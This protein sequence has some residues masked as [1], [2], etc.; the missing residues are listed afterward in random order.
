MYYKGLSDVF[1]VEDSIS[2]HIPHVVKDA[3]N[4]ST[5]LGTAQLPSWCQSGFEIN[6]SSLTALQHRHNLELNLGKSA[7]RC[8]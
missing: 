2:S 5:K 3:A 8:L 1:T 6:P 7:G 4:S